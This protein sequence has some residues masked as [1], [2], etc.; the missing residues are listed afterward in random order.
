M[1][2]YPERCRRN[3]LALMEKLHT[4]A[5]TAYAMMLM[6]AALMDLRTDDSEVTEMILKDCGY[7]E[8]R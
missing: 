2:A 8:V 1:D 5:E 4:D 3:I 7:V 6:T